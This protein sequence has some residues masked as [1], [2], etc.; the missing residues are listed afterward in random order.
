MRQAGGAEL[1]AGACPECVVL[2]ECHPAD[3]RG[4]RTRHSGGQGVLGPAADPIHG[5]RKTPAPAAGGA[6][7]LGGQHGMDVARPQP[8]VVGCERRQ[9]AADHHDVAGTYRWH[10]DV[11]ARAQ[12][13]ALAT[14]G[15]HGRT[16]AEGLAPH[17]LEQRRLAGDRVPEQRPERGAVEPLEP[18]VRQGDTAEHRRREG[19]SER[20]PQ[21][22]EPEPGDRED[23]HERGPP[24]SGEQAADEHCRRRLDWVAA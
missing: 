18:R 6:N 12:Q 23:R 19:H 2:A 1:L 4:L 8:C 9:G 20:P 14:P 16:A 13:H 5:A 3:E 10:A 22:T 7:R 24:R 15:H 17:R 21:A 11:G